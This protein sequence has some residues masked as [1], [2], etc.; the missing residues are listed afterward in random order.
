MSAFLQMSMHDVHC[1]GVF[2]LCW[3]VPASAH[4]LV[5]LSVLAKD[6]HRFSVVCVKLDRFFE[7]V[8]DCS[9]NHLAKHNFV[10]KGIIEGFSKQPYQ[11]NVV[12]GRPCCQP[13]L[14]NQLFELC[15]YLFGHFLSLF[16]VFQ[17]A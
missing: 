6:G 10:S 3:S 17:F 2:L 15:D 13:R 7:P 1:I 4:C 8:F 11:M 9:W 16:Q 12:R 5:I 14:S